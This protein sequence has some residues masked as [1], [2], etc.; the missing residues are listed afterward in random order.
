MVGEQQNRN[1]GTT[2]SPQPGMSNTRKDNIKRTSDFTILQCN[3]QRSPSKH[4][5]LLHQAFQTEVDII[6]VQEPWAARNQQKTQKHPG[7]NMFAPMGTWTERPRVMTYTKKGLHAEVRLIGGRE[8]PDLTQLIVRLPT[9]AFLRIFNIY[10]AGI[11][12]VRPNESVNTLITQGVEGRKTIICGDFNLHHHAWDMNATRDDA[13]AN[14]FIDWTQDNDLQLLTDRETPTRDRAVLDLT[15][16]S[17]NVASRDQRI[18]AE[19]ATNLSCGSDHLPVLT[20]ITKC[21][22]SGEMA[23]TG[24]FQIDKM[25]DAE[26][27]SQCAN[28]LK[29][30]VF[31][32]HV[33]REDREAELTRLALGMQLAIYTALRDTTPRTSGKGRGQRWWTPEL[34]QLAKAHRQACGTWRAAQGFEDEDDARRARNQTSRDLARGVR[35]AKTKFFQQVINEVRE[36]KDVFRAAKWTRSPQKF[37][38]SAMKNENGGL[39]EATRE[40][41]ELLLH[42]H[43]ASDHQDDL[44]DTPAMPAENTRREWRPLSMTEVKRAVFRPA[45]TAPGVDNIPNVVLKKAWPLAGSMIVRLYNLSLNWGIVPRVFKEARLCVVPKAGKRDWTH[46]RSYR[47]IALLPTLAK[48]L[49]RTLARRLAFEAVHFVIIPRKYLCAVPRRATT[50]LLLDLVDEVQDVVKRQKKFATLATFDIKGAFDAV[51]PRRLVKRLIEQFWPIKICR[52]VASFLEERVADMTFDGMVGE[53]NKLGG[54]LPQGSPISPILFMLFLSPL[55]NMKASLRGYADDGAILVTGSSLQDNVSKTQQEL[56]DVSDWC[57]RNGLQ[58]DLKKTDLI[59]LTN[60][61]TTENPDIALPNGERQPAILPGQSLKWL[62]VHFDRKLNFTS[63]IDQACQRAGDV[64]NGIRLLAGCYKGAPV[65]SMLNLV[66][67]G[68]LPILTYGFQAW[69]RLPTDKQKAQKKHLEKFNKVMKR[70]IRAALPVYRTTPSHLLHHAAGIPPMEIILDDL[71]RG[72]A[73]RS[74]KFDLRHP[75]K[76]SV[77]RGRVQYIHSALL[78]KPIENVTHDASSLCWSGPTWE[79]AADFTPRAKDDQERHHQ[80]EQQN[81]P[82]EDVWV[83]TDGSRTQTGG[84]GA[85]WAVY[86]NKGQNSICEGKKT[87]GNW[88]E[89]IDAEAEAALEG[90]R[91]ALNTVGNQRCKL[92]LCLD[93]QSVLRRLAAPRDHDDCGTSQHVIDTARRFLRHWQGGVQLRWVP[94]HTNVRGNEKAD[95][96]AKSAAADTGGSANEH[97]TTA[98]ANR[99]RKAKLEE[100]FQ[101]WWKSNC[102]PQKAIEKDMEYPKPWSATTKTY[103]GL[104]RTHVGRVLAARSGHGDFSAYHTRFTHENAALLCGRCSKEK[105]ELHPWTC[106]SRQRH[107]PERFIRKL[108]TSGKGLRLLTKFLT[109]EDQPPN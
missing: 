69:W 41:I 6:C 92:W 25:D 83:Y 106:R 75:L 80:N 61:R 48:G 77:H 28:A 29:D 56:R 7:Y 66:R 30:I 42:T 11:D 57:V 12:S 52:W 8:Q 64:I 16:A 55:Y 63:H 50:D 53:K 49:E 78:P 14:T 76:Q 17:R 95:E 31:R 33:P 108:A 24:A 4:A 102:R 19:V 100:D 107:R 2:A 98:N 39:V 74:A 35:K 18:T 26:F 58:L 34:G 37:M 38:S 90:I 94:G 59:H 86:D 5:A 1:N 103:Q 45:N 3:T 51:G 40:K 87:C 44:E 32:E 15:L 97:M 43:V 104:N 96:L 82:R 54:S 99:W 73:I 46:P 105:T 10:N 71:L 62:G 9:G 20:T 91:S 22:S 72:E 68:V 60:K 21:Y 65:D 67:A 88:R 109:E 85:G 47:L 81:A 23:A 89:V 70:A 84:T 79:T 36:P 27:A 101:N 13:L 93:N